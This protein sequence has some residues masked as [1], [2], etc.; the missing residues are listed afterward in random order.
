M[1]V[2]SIVLPCILLAAKSR[3]V[4]WARERAAP[5]CRGVLERDANRVRICFITIHQHD[6]PVS[7]WPANGIRGNEYISFAVPNFRGGWKH[8]MH[9][10]AMLH[11]FEINHVRGVIERSVASDVVIVRRHKTRPRSPTQAAIL[12]ALRLNR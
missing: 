3:R 9:A 12:Q 1:T 6:R 5:F 10:G 8:F 7:V 11:P 2:R 4:Y